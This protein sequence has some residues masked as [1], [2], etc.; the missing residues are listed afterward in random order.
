[1]LG[2]I[3]PEFPEA[4]EKNGID[5]VVKVNFTLGGDGKIHN[6]TIA[7]DLPFGAGAFALPASLVLP[8]PANHI[9]LN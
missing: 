9:K 1:M 3:H 2:D 8:I 7:Q 6:A 4:A 5:G